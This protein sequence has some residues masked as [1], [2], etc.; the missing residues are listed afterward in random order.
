MGGGGGEAQTRDHKDFCTGVYFVLSYFLYSFPLKEFLT[1]MSPFAQTPNIS[2]MPHAFS[3]LILS[4]SRYVN[5]IFE[6]PCTVDH[7]L[8]IPLYTGEGIEQTS[9]NYCLSNCLYNVHTVFSTF[10]KI[11]FK[12]SSKEWF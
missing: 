1:L 11:N 10:N 8:C 3:S 12:Q 7:G 2:R 6:T 9:R 5:S 4:A